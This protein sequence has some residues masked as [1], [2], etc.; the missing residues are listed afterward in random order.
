MLRSLRQPDILITTLAAAGIMMVTM[1]ARQSLEI[2]VGP[3]EISTGVEI[4]SISLALAIGQFT[5]GAIQPLAGIVADLFGPR[6][7]LIGG[8]L[9]LAISCAITPFM[10]P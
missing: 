10:S 9:L 1:G 3:I 5:W 7:V 6:I 8:L 4:T 2:F